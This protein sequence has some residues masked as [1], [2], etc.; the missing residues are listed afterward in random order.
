[1]LS[2]PGL[3]VQKVEKHLI[4]LSVILL[5]GRASER[6]SFIYE[7]LEKAVLESNC[8][9]LHNIL[10]LFCSA[11]ETRLS[12]ISD[13][14]HNF[15]NILREGFTKAKQ[16]LLNC[17]D[18]FHLRLI[19]SMCLCAAFMLADPNSAKR[20]SRQAAFCTFGICTSKAVCKHVDE[21]DLRWQFHQHFTC[22]FF[23]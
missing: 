17:F 11:G 4:R 15:S 13:Q 16:L 8:N 23:V 22:R 2:R 14:E 10:C 1:M 20:Q 5:S 6:R 19:S 3:G 21:I 12:S 9:H 7:I 18:N